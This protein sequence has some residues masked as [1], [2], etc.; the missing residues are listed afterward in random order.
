VITLGE[1]NTPLCAVSS[2]SSL[3]GLPQ[4]YIKNESTNP[5]WSYKD[6]SNTV[7]ISVAKEMGFKKVVAVS[8]GN[9]GVSAAAYSAAAGLQ[10]VVLCHEDV[11]PTLV[12]L[13]HLYGGKAI[14]GENRDSFLAALVRQGDW[15][16]AVTVAPALDVCSPYGVEGFKTI[17]YEL[18]EQLSGTVPDCVF[19]PV[20]SGDGCY[21]VWKGFRDLRSLGLTQSAPRMYACQAEGCNPLVRSYRAASLEVETVDQGYTMALSIR[22]PKSSSLALRAVYDSKGAAV[23]CSEAE[24]EDVW[25]MLGKVGLFVEPASAVA[26]ACAKKLAKAGRIRERDRVV[27]ILTGAGI[28]WPEF[29]AAHSALPHVSGPDVARIASVAK[30][31]A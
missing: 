8:T 25:K 9:H 3:L 12:R 29:L 17:A 21:G 26:V 24:I 28:K 19:V 5:T 11:S 30:E 4:L 20:G 16:P 1:G 7:A 27:C 10:C 31:S 23:D 18:F 13:I 6:R 14:V 2:V 22:E 15:F